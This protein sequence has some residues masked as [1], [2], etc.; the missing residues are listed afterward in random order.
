MVYSDGLNKLPNYKITCTRTAMA[1]TTEQDGEHCTPNRSSVN[2]N[3][4]NMTKQHNRTLLI[5]LRAIAFVENERWLR[6]ETTNTSK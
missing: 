6:A 1:M 2:A 5:C 4:Q 3:T